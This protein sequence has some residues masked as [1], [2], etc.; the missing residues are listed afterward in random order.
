MKAK[1]SVAVRMRPLL[2][3]EI[4]AGDQSTAIL[5][6]ESSNTIKYPSSLHDRVFVGEKSVKEFAFDR[7]LGP[8]TTQADVYKLT[9]ISRMID[10]VVDGYHATVL[11][12]GQTGAGKTY[13][14]DGFHYSLDARRGRLCID[15]SEED[16]WGVIPR[17]VSY[18]FGK[19]ASESSARRRRYVAHCSYL[20]IYNERIYDLLN[21]SQLSQSDPAA[22]GLK[23]RYRNGNF[24]VDNL[25]RFECRTAQDVYSLLQFGLK[26][27][28]V[29]GHK[30]NRASSRSHSVLCLTIESFDVENQVNTSSNNT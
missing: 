26:N 10:K 24:T 28:A 7:V 29:A 15:G 4:A 9:R 2:E 12:Y 13:T 1:I 20:Q 21:S 22:S 6:D 3:S 30:L 11:V 5:A 27:R 19:I 16:N 18:L 17:A 14:M 8:T 25:H 23:L